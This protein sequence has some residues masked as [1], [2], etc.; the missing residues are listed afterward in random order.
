MHCD[1]AYGPGDEE[2][3]VYAVQDGWARPALEGYTL[4]TVCAFPAA[5][6]SHSE[7]T[8][9]ALGSNQL[10]LNVFSPSHGKFHLVTSELFHIFLDTLE[11]PHDSD[12]L[13][14]L[15]PPFWCI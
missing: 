6:V 5:S 13:P 3:Q 1:G 10:R 4:R 9:S 2:G 11:K 12:Q 14:P 7:T 8:G 15:P